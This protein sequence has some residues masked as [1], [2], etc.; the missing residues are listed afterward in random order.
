MPRPN[1]RNELA[2]LLLSHDAKNF[3]MSE[4]SSNINKGEMAP[5][6]NDSKDKTATPP[7]DVVEEITAEDLRG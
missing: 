3:P 5:R 4:F 6:E 7:A 1:V 2:T